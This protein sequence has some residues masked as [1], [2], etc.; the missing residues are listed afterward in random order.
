LSCVPSVFVDF[1]FASF[2][3]VLGLVNVI[4]AWVGICVLLRAVL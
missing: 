1:M 3:V 2:L 4:I